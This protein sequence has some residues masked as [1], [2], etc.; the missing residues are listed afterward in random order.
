MLYAVKDVMV[1]TMSRRR[2]PT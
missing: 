1:C 2:M